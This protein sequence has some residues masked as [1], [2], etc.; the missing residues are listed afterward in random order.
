MIQYVMLKFFVG[1]ESSI[2]QFKLFSNSYFSTNN[3]LS[4]DVRFLYGRG[5]SG[6]VGGMQGS[7]MIH[8]KADLFFWCC[9]WFAHDGEAN[10]S[11]DVI[12]M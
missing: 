7:R 4:S 9:L 2:C 10:G 3:L 11:C 12:I 6:L 1:Y 8:G 5:V